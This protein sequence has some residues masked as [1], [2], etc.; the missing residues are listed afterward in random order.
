MNIYVIRFE[1]RAHLEQN[2]DFSW[3]HYIKVQ[4][5]SFLLHF[6][7]CLYLL[8]LLRYT[9]LDLCCLYTCMC[10]FD[11]LTMLRESS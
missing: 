2:V 5:V 7:L 1:E 4:L 10:M 6:V 3:S 11:Y 9:H 8:P